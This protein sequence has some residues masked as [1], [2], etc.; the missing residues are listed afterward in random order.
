MHIASQLSARGFPTS[1]LSY[2][3]EYAVA[4]ETMH[5]MAVHCASIL[6]QCHE[7]E[8]S[9]RE[10]SSCHSV[11]PTVHHGVQHSSS[12]VLGLDRWV[13]LPHMLPT[14]LKQPTAGQQQCCFYFLAYFTAAAAA[15]RKPAG[16]H[17]TI[18][19]STMNQATDWLQIRNMSQSFPSVCLV[20]VV[21]RSLLS[22]S[23]WPPSS[24]S[25]GRLVWQ[26]VQGVGRQ[27]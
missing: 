6:A 26:G 10:R 14:Q 20:S 15:F 25:Y 13:T 12:S 18:V 2:T 21:S 7:A 1:A 23:S 22:V 19:P 9:Q 8:E 3:G 17:N 27:G 5:P 24:I 11:R 4:G 16:H